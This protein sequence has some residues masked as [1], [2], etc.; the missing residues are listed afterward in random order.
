MLL[1]S[2]RRS[3]TLA[4]LVLAWFVFA[5]GVAVAAP[6]LQPMDLGGICSA[7]ATAEGGNA[8]DGSAAAGAH[9][10]LQCVLCLAAGAPPST[11]VA[12]TLGF[13][14]ATEHQA[15]RGQV[16]VLAARQSPLIARAPPTRA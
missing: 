7:T 13:S 5:M 4:R 9:H 2:L 6:T 10:G 3:R 12:A 15:V 14:G 1:H 16:P 8:P 11:P